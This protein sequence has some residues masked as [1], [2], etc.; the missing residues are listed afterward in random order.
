MT[1]LQKQRLKAV[2]I[3][4]EKADNNIPMLIDYYLDDH[5][6]K[7]L[8][9]PDRPKDHLPY[10]GWMISTPFPEASP[11]QTSQQGID[12]IKR[13]EGCR[14][15]AYLCPANVWTIGYGHTGTATPG[16]CISYERAEELLKV[17][18]QRFEKAV[19]NCVKVPINQN[20]FDALVSLAYN[21][22]IAAFSNSTLLTILNQKSYALSAEQFHRWN[23]VGKVTLK[24]LTDRRKEEY[25]LFMS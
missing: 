24:G 16:M 22:G 25:Q 14:L 15:G 2:R 7:V 17:D 9:L 23:R 10:S 19:R 1:Q 13:W 18:L 3:L 6:R 21:I 12:L 20:Q 11:T 4:I 8:G 5:L